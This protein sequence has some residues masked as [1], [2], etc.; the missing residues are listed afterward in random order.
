MAI[1]FSRP[2]KGYR[3]WEEIFLYSHQNCGHYTSSRLLY[4]TTFWILVPS[5]DLDRIQSPKHPVLN[6]RQD[7]GYCSEL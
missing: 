5:E 3:D 2:I 6:K 1:L 4:K 7:C